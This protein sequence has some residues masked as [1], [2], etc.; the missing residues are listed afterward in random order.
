MRHL[1]YMKCERLRFMSYGGPSDM[2]S[3]MMTE[4]RHLP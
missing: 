2:T 3:D 4:I 1:L